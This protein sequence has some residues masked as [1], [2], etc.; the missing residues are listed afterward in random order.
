MSDITP[1]VLKKFQYKR[2]V[3]W[4]EIVDFLQDQVKATTAVQWL[5]KSGKALSI[6]KGLYYLK[7][8]NEWLL[9]E[10]EINP[11]LIAGH[12]HPEGVIGYH[13]ALKCYGV[14]YSE[15][16]LFQIALPKSVRR[17]WKA[18]SFQKANYEFYRANLTFGITSSVVEDVRVQHFS[19]E[20]ILLEG[21]MYPNRL[22]GMDEFVKSVEG[23]SWINL[24]HLF[25]MVIHYPI[26]TISMRL[27][28]L[29]EKNK[30]QWHV[31]ES[32]LKRLEKNRTESRILL[33]K[34]KPKGNYLVKRWSLMVP[35]TLRT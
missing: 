35:R 20:R 30:R 23:F 4:K 32:D 2:V 33:V 7:R 8:P 1:Q 27:G 28:W 25:E 5:L 29:L 22:L 6:K 17:T 3:R 19:R 9:D 13:A 14:A 34:S 26:K 15:S 16:N 12:I 18:F 31:A 10:L 24:E 11:L 21:L